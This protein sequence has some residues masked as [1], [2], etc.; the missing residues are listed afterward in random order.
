MKSPQ[1]NNAVTL[2]FPHQLFKHHPAISAERKIFMVE[3]WLF[4]NQ[5]G[6]IKQKLVLHRASMQFYRS[7]LQPQ[8]EVT[9][10]EAT[11]DLCDIRKLIK[12]LAVKGITEIHYAEVS[13]DWLEK[14]ISKTAA[15]HNIQTIKYHGPDF[16]NKLSDVE[17]YFNQ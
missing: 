3:E 14:R 8:Y 9:Y 1:V 12:F 4:F 15:S 2:I 11:D 17:E 13:D 5:F 16:L 10:I 6:F 7:Y